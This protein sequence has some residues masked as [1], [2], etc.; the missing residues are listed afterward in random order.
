MIDIDAYK[1]YAFGAVTGRV[2]TGLYRVLTLGA[3]KDSVAHAWVVLETG[4]A[5]YCIQFTGNLGISSFSK[6]ATGGGRLEMKRFGSLNACHEFGISCVTGSDS[7][8]TAEWW[9]EYSGKAYRTTSMQ[10]VVDWMAGYYVNC[11]MTSHN[12]QDFV[13]DFYRKFC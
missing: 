6:G 8:S 13:R 3:S 2:L 9:G 1:C 7:D 4:P 5:F 12:C 10:E 11:D